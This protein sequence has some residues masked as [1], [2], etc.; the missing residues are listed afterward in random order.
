MMMEAKLFYSLRRDLTGSD[1]SVLHIP[2]IMKF[3]SFFELPLPTANK[4]EPEAISSSRV[5]QNSNHSL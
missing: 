2:F 5:N 4:P 1:N 3:Q